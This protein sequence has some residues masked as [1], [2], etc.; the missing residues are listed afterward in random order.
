MKRRS[1]FGIALLLMATAAN[2]QVKG[3]GPMADVIKIT[4]QTFNLEKTGWGKSDGYP[5]HFYRDKRGNWAVI[6]E[7]GQQMC[8][9]S[10]GSGYIELGLSGD[11]K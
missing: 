3:C 9:L 11:K 5:V 10:F 1:L 8:I 2:A 4:E 7:V 6:Q